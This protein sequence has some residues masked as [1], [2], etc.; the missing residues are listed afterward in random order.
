MRVN[1]FDCGPVQDSDGLKGLCVCKCGRG[2]GGLGAF[3]CTFTKQ[4][5]WRA[6]RELPALSKPIH[7]FSYMGIKLTLLSPANVTHI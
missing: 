3:L 1:E 6:A 7:L 4:C 2:D 5:R